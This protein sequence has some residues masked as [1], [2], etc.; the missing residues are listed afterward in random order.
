MTP[1]QKLARL[2]EVGGWG[3]VEVRLS[4]GARRLDGA[5]VPSHGGASVGRVMRH[6]GLRRRQYYSIFERHL[7]DGQLEIKDPSTGRYV[8]LADI[9]PEVYAGV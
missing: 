6:E 8:P 1:K 2:V 9:N 7:D 5:L 4:I 3:R